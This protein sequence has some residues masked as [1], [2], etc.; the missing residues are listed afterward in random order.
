MM[1]Y[2]QEA[3]GFANQM[4]GDIPGEQGARNAQRAMASALIGILEEM[5][6]I[7]EIL[8]W[9]DAND[10]RVTELRAAAEAPSWED[11]QRWEKET[12]EAP[13]ELPY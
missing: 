1:D 8:Q 7:H 2:L 9:S 4:D 5:Q 10:R 12:E 11:M 6:G 3:K 13:S